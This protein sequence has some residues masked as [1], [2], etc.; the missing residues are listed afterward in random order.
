MKV[1]DLITTYFKGF[2]ELVRIERRWEY[3]LGTTLYQ[4]QANCKSIYDP[5][6]CGEEMSPLFYFKQKYSAEGKPVNIKTIK[7]C[8]AS[9]C[10]PAQQFIKEE[11]VRLQTIMDNIK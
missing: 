7:C 3:R 5:E 10:K 6:T 1:G 8:S 9:F 4:K 11:I 2:Y